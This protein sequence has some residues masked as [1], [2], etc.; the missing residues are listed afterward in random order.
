MKLRRNRI[1]NSENRK[2]PTWRSTLLSLFVACTLVVQPAQLCALLESAPG[3]SHDDSH[4]HQGDSHHAKA[5]PA[6]HVHEAAS[7]SHH[8]HDH[9]T[10]D[11]HTHNSHHEVAHQPTAR[12]SEYRLFIQPVPAPHVCCSDG[13]STPVVTA[14]TRRSAAPHE[15]STDLAFEHGVLP[16]MPD[17]FALTACH[18]RDGPLGRPLR[19]Q[20][21]AASLLGRAP[22]A[23]V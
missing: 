14:T 17:S 1:G 6:V 15:R 8:P 23:L 5:S 18:G 22:P 11:S 3:H 12:A 20:F 4:S 13:G 7:S 9:A 10:D 2:C 21:S 19:S 16:T